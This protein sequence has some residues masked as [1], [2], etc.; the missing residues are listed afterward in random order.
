[1]WRSH[2][3]PCS[4]LCRCAFMLKIIRSTLAG[5]NCSGSN[6]CPGALPNAQQRDRS[7][8]YSSH[9]FESSHVVSGMLAWTSDRGTDFLA[10]GQNERGGRGWRDRAGNVGARW[11]RIHETVETS[12]WRHCGMFCSC[13]DRRS[14]GRRLHFYEQVLSL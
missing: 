2:S 9:R 12:Y 13:A 4:K 11:R 1:M 5:C 10:T 8:V 14:A 6:K 3:A 7:S